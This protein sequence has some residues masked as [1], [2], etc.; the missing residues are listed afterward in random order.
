MMPTSIA[1]LEASALLL[2]P[3]DRAQLAD[4]LLASLSSDTDLDDAWSVE[5][6]RRL[7]E[8]ECGSV[9]GVPIADAIARARNAIK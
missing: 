6:D 8:L 7:S 9:I 1:E 2:A 3:E 5:A 4:R